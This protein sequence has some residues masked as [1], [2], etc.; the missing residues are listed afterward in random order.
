MDQTELL[1]HLKEQIYFIEKCIE[2]YDKNEIE[3]K[4]VAT[5]IRTLVHDTSISISLLKQLNL[6]ERMY[7]NTNVPKNAFAYWKVSHIGMSGGTINNQTPY[8]GIVGK[9]VYGN[10]DGSISIKYFPIYKEWKDFSPSMDFDTWWNAEIYD[11]R[12]GDVLTRKG[13]ILNVANK[14]GGAH[15]DNLKQEY[16]SFKKNDIIQFKVNE[17]LQG[18]DNIPAYPAVIQ[19]AW[20]LLNSIKNEINSHY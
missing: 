8:I 4:R 9:E 1:Q 6:K 18:F 5:H 13:L 3:A 19:I 11:N 7:I 12:N 15:I 20:E 14:D 16:R 10:S 17:N 2:D